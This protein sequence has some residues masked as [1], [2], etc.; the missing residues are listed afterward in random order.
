M[1]DLKWLI[2]ETLDIPEIQAGD[3]ILD[4]CFAL[5]PMISTALMGDGQLQQISDYYKLD[6]F[7]A[8]K[9][10]LMKETKKIWRALVS[11]GY[12]VESPDYT[13]QTEGK[14][15]LATL[16]IIGGYDESE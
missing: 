11:D 13:W 3:P 5:N 6:M 4:G 8:N 1:T 10:E 2:E 9:K 12:V 14:I 15:W 16:T 7:Y